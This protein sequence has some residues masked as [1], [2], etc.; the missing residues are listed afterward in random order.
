MQMNI[1]KI[2]EVFG[3]NNKLPRDSHDHP[4]K[5]RQWGDRTGSNQKFKEKAIG[6]YI[7]VG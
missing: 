4:L 7:F 6:K 1:Y 3:A 2:F 5:S